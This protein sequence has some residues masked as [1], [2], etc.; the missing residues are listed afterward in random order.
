VTVRGVKYTV[1]D[2]GNRMHFWESALMFTLF[3]LILGV[4]FFVPCG[5]V[6]LGLE[7]GGLLSAILGGCFGLGFSIVAGINL[8]AWIN[9]GSK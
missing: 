7:F 9:G 4:L 3:S 2:K 5:L 1:Q 6:L 8:A